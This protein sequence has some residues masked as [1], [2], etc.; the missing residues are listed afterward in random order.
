MRQ[1]VLY[2][3][4]QSAYGLCICSHKDRSLMLLCLPYEH[5]ADRHKRGMINCFNVD[6][7]FYIYTEIN[8]GNLVDHKQG[9][10][11]ELGQIE[12]SVMTGIAHDIMDSP[13]AF[14]INR[15]VPK[16]PS[17]EN[18]F[19]RNFNMPTGMKVIGGRGRL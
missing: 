18:R 5:C 1:S 10:E 4:D 16:E 6:G 17:L 2:Q 12:Q 3:I 15:Y 9:D 14:K 13:V 7:Q 8:H 11:T 19:W